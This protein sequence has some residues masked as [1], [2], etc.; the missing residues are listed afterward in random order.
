VKIY[1]SRSGNIFSGKGRA[2]K[3]FS[4][5]ATE[6]FLK[7]YKPANSIKKIYIPQI[8]GLNPN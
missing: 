6:I 8:F 3:V 7:P 4:G 5:E 2:K 1:G